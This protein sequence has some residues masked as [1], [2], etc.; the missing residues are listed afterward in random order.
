[1]G[2]AGKFPA[3]SRESDEQVLAGLRLRQVMSARDAA[4]KVEMTL[5][6]LRTVTAAVRDEDLKICGAVDRQSGQ[7]V[8][9]FYSWRG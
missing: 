7:V 8:A 6:R 9:A 2:R 4:P 5:P 3:A 1:M